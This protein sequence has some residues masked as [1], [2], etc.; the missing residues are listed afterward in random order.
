MALG[1]TQP[2]TEMSSRNI[3]WGVKTAG[4]KTLSLSCSDCLEMWEPQT[5]GPLRACPGLYKD[6]FIAIYKV[7]ICLNTTKLY[8]I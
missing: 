3:S 4:A 1:S 7:D 5:A 2:L 6:S 8:F